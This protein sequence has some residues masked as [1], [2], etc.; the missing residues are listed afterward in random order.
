MEHKGFLLDESAADREAQLVGMKIALATQ[1]QDDA[2]DLRSDLLKTLVLSVL[3]K[4]GRCTLRKLAKWASD[5]LHLPRMVRDEFFAD[6]L[7]I[8]RK[9]NLIQL[10]GDTYSLTG[11]GEDLI[12]AEL[13]AGNNR[14]Q[15]GKKHVRERMAEL[16][17]Q[18]LD[19][20]SFEALWNRIQEE[21]A[22]IFFFTGLRA[23]SCIAS[24]L[25]AQGYPGPERPLDELFAGVRR[26]IARMGIGGP[27]AEE[28]GQA[29]VDLFGDCDSELFVWLTDVA[30]KYVGLCSLGLEPRAQ[31]QV[32]S[33]LEQIDLIVD[34]DVVLSFLS[35]GER[36]HT[37]IEELLR[38]WVLIG[39]KVLV[40]PPVL[41][42]VAYHAWISEFEYQEVWRLLAKLQSDEINRYVQKAF[43]RAFA[44]Q[45]GGDFSPGRWH[46]FISEYRGLTPID[47]SKIQAILRDE[48][49]EMVEDFAFDPHFAQKVR[50][51]LF[52]LRR[53]DDT[54]FVPKAV[55]DKVARDARIV[56]FL[57][58]RRFQTR[59]I[60]RTTIILSSSPIL[61][62]AAAKFE[63]ELGGPSPVWPVGALAYLVSLVPGVR[64]TVSSLRKCL[65]D[66]GESDPLDKI[67]RMA[68]RVIRQ[69]NQYEIGYSRRPTLRR[70]L[71]RR[72]AIAAKERGQ[73]ASLLAEELLEP[74]EESKAILTEVLAGAIDEIA[75]SRSEAELERRKPTR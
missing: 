14:L 60:G 46:A 7:P 33:H 35:T 5:M 65:F 23:I 72:V 75:V 43:V 37:T 2:R 13:D 11:P 28:V 39:G 21:F 58:Q 50:E 1:F 31:D 62:Q 67:S 26:N 61:Q 41:E 70:E 38:R 54:T 15:T 69:S 63:S 29:V 16:L 4:Q 8:L 19:R 74:T 51:E 45:A 24:L 68:L 9:Q 6:I 34:T 44:R 52:R 17:G 3:F 48:K 71:T 47:D 12:R 22:T 49:F 36:P 56:S 73:K 53:I 30:V 18:E 25:D 55:G 40:P 27:R 64:M 32:V 20:N 10:E 66:E 57:K 59:S 42:E